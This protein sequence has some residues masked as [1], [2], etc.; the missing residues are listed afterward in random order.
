METF[1]IISIGQNVGD[2][3]GY[4]L[5]ELELSP[6]NPIKM[7]KYGNLT[8]LT[9]LIEMAEDQVIEQRKRV[10]NYISDHDK[11]LLCAYD[12][13]DWMSAYILDK[14]AFKTSS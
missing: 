5:K 11:S 10:M 6:V 9:F 4:F 13:S 12:R 7:G 3:V 2:R 8:T 1:K 14:V